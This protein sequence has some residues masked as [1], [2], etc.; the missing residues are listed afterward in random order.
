MTRIIKLLCVVL[1]TVAGLVGSSLPARADDRHDRCVRRVQQAE[2]NLRDAIARHGEDSR[3]AR[4]RR[5]QLDEAR[6]ECPDVE[7]H[8]DHDHDHDHDQH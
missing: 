5:A 1:L 3:A 8:D 6:H 2:A 4:K 7:H